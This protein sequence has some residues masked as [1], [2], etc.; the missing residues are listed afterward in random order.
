MDD[1]RFLRGAAARD[2]VLGPEYAA[3]RAGAPKSVPAVESWRRYITEEGWG[4]VWTRAGL[5]N[6]T[7]SL[8]TVVA[9]AIAGKPKELELHLVGAIRNGWTPDELAEVF[10]HLTSYVGYPT[11]VEA[12]RVAEAVFARADDLGRAVQPEDGPPGGEE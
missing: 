4:G 3:I 7:R 11:G 6:K 8:V 5:P 10:I 2:N 9:L 1:Q 12:F